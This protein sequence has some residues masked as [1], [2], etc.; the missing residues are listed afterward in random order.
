VSRSRSTNQPAPA[1]P[2][3][4]TQQDIAE[5]QEALGHLYNAVDSLQ[6][7]TS[8][9]AQHT[10]VKLDEWIATN[11]QLLATFQRLLE[12]IA[13]N[14]ETS[15][16]S[17]VFSN[18]QQGL[19]GELSNQLNRFQQAFNLIHLNQ[20]AL[21]SVAQQAETMQNGFQMHNQRLLELHEQLRGFSPASTGSIESTATA[22]SATE[23][24]EQLAGLFSQLK[25]ELKE[26]LSGSISRSG[27]LALPAAAPRFSKMSWCPREIVAL[28]VVA[29]ILGIGTGLG[30]GK[31]TETRR[32]MRGLTPKESE[33]LGWAL[34][35]EGQLARN[36]MRWNPSIPELCAQSKT[37]LQGRCAVWVIP[38]GDRPE[39]D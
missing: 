18:S 20:E 21:Q 5:L 34:T 36:I 32:D 14:S 35:G 4:A 1:P 25:A 37:E 19:L 7:E 30:V 27:Q 9:S 3:A 26:G 13:L 10:H 15:Q 12:A 33:L 24:G 17:L 22:L 39:T 29:G 23:M 8:Q 11:Q 16:Q 31:V 2:L 28:V 38:P 6:G